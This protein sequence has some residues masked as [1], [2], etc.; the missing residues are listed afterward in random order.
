L[1][2]ETLFGAIISK[3]LWYLSISRNATV[4]LI[5]S[6]IAFY[7]NTT[8]DK[9]IFQLSGTVVSGIPEFRLPDF[10]IEV[11]VSSEVTGNGINQSLFFL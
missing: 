6:A 8:S 5:T 10:D 3:M 11:I 4:V 2:K 7:W 9:S 1:N